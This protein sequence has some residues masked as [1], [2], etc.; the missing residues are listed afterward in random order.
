MLG[1][2][3]CSCHLQ[4]IFLIW[5]SQ[6]PKHRPSSAETICLFSSIQFFFPYSTKSQQRSAKGALHC[7]V[8][9]LQSSG[10][11]PNNLQQE[12]FLP[13]K[14]PKGKLLVRDS[15]SE[16]SWFKPLKP[17][18]VTGLRGSFIFG[19]MGAFL[20]TCMFHVFIS[21]K[22][23]VFRSGCFQSCSVW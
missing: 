23:L 19:F 13:V 4:G 10:E 3:P 17:V 15:Q 22:A 7:Q 1:W 16:N 14:R 6:V 5:L 20:W 8:K 9:T 11:K 2:F 18:T 21:Q 12:R